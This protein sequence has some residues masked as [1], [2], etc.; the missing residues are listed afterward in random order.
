MQTELMNVTGMACESC[1]SKVD[2]A[3]SAVPGVNSVEVS[4]MADEA[5]VQYD[6]QLTSSA[7]L[8]TVV[9]DAGYGVDGIG[10]AQAEQGGCC[11]G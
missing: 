6:E 4:L 9:R 7:Q 10:S 3:L 8:K 11:C 1:A 2:R 5:T